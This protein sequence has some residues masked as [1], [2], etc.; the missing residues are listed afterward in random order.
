MIRLMVLLTE[1]AKT[2]HAHSTGK[3]EVTENTSRTEHG[4]DE[5]TALP[6]TKNL[7]TEIVR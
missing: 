3:R 7:T 1:P 6:K 5:L 2:P 4:S